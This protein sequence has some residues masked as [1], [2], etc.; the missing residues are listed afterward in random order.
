MSAANRGSRF[1]A[2]AASVAL[3]VLIEAPAAVAQQE[4]LTIDRITS[5]PSI[6]G[7]PPSEP[8]W[9]PDSTRIA[10]LWNDHAMPFRDIWIANVSG[11]APVRV[12]KLEE[13]EPPAPPPGK[14]LSLK[15]LTERAAARTRSG[16]ADVIWT[17]DGSALIF[18]YRG[19]LHRI[20]PDGSG[21]ERLTTSGGGKSRMTYSPDGRQLAFLQ[22]G[23]LYLW[24]V[25]ER[26]LI[27]ATNVGIPPINSV[28]GGS[29]YSMEVEIRSFE[30]SPDSTR[31]AVDYVDRRQIRKVPFPYYLSD[32]PTMN[33]A[34]RTFPGDVA[35][36]RQL[37]VYGLRD[38]E[39]KFVD[40][41]EKNSR[42]I[43]SYEWSPDSASLLVEQDTDVAMDRWLY[44]VKADD[45]STRQ[46]WHDQRERRIYPAFASTWR[47]DGQAVL[48]ISD[49]SDQYRLASIPAAGGT[50]KMLTSGAYDV[51]GSGGA[52]PLIVS[53]KTNDVFFVSSEK[54]PYERHVYRMPQRGG[55]ATR[56]TARD[57]MHSPTVSPDGA[58]VALLSSS[59]STPLELYIADASGGK[60]RRDHDLAAEGVLRPHVGEGEVRHLQEPAQR[61]HAARPHPGAA[62]DGGSGRKYPVILGPVY[63]NTVRNEWRG[64]ND[65][66]AQMLAVERGYIVVQVDLRGSM[67]YGVKFRE[68]FQG[69]WGG[70]DLEDLHSTVDY[71][72]TLPNVDGDRIG[73]WGSS[74][75]GMITLFAL[76]KKPGLFHAGVAAAPAVDV[77]QFT[78]FDQHL[79][80]RPNTHPET[81]YNSTVNNF[82]EDL[83]DPLLIIHGMQDDIVPFQTTVQLAEKLMLLGKDFDFAFAPTAPHAWSRKDYYARYMWKKLVQHFDRYLAPATRPQPT[84]SGQQRN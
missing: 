84:S 50:P 55:G 46:L 56:V 73:I 74:Y 57:G 41:P 66:L 24:R 5:L 7:T 44:V 52:T 53:A 3:F 43:L 60:E 72:K 48:F 36:A 11:G 9:S 65:T 29:F 78:T 58:R 10:F 1:L 20:A 33:W 30:W 22:G 37:G 64:Q 14:N 13:Q 70:G 16:I 26:S 51:A 15:A 6:T 67:G 12:T 76:F 69:D 59:N 4:A 8:V 81:F 19:D 27:R 83:R 25:A 39:V 38:G 82:G 49:T 31:L 35:E 40:L 71:L 2:T 21:L 77:H 80:R 17:P 28:G 75:G 68:S 63:S 23:D 42:S 61:L 18:A 45:R 54:S 62:D 79:S 32:E 47:S 34:R